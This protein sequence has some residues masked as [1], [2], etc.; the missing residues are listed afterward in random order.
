MLKAAMQDVFSYAPLGTQANYI[1]QRRVTKNLPV[2]ETKFH[3][4]FSFALRHFTNFET[5]LPTVDAS[6]AA[7]F[8]FGAG[9]DLIIPL[10]Y[11]AL[12]IERQTLVDIRP[13]MRFELINDTLRRFTAKHAELEALAEKPLR[14][15]G[16]T[17]VT[18]I[19][20][21]RTRFGVTYLAPCDARNT[22]LSAESIDM[23]TS[24]ATLEHIPG[25]DILKILKECRRLLKPGGIVSSIIDM[26]DHYS[27]F[28][29]HITVYNFLTL[30]DAAWRLANAPLG[31]QNRLR[32]SEY[33]KLFAS[34]NLE[35]L[36]EEIKGPSDAERLALKAMKLAPRFRHTYTIDDLGARSL[37]LISRKNGH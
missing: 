4:K 36:A 16:A 20:D 10:T 5:W 8:E 35:T 2:S 11:Y 29:S 27:Y 31:Y 6:D 1:M 32:Y 33:M 28:D 15:V 21:L 30:S 13:N 19:A 26:Q 12:G 14:P 22:N 37:K 9:W 24:T 23:V 18:S 17:P 34:A 3:E 25:P 7:F